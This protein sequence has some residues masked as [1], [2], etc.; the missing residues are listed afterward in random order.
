MVWMKNQ[1]A[2]LSISDDAADANSQTPLVSVIIPAYNAENYIVATL[3]S[4]LSQTYTAIEVLVVDDG[5]SDRTPDIIRSFAEKDKRVSLIQQV[6]AGVAA[7]RNLA[8]QKSR[9]EYIA[10]ID[11]DDIWFPQKLEK[12]VQCMLNSDSSVGLIY[13]WS[14]DINEDG[15]LTGRASHFSL[16]GDVFLPLVYTNFLGNA[17]VPL[18]RRECFEKVGYYNAEYVKLNAQGCED[19]DLHLRIAEHYQFRV[20]PELLVGY[21]K[22]LG[23]MSNNYTSMEKSHFLIL[24][25]VQSKY[26]KIPFEIYRWSTSNFCTYLATQSWRAGNHKNTLLWLYRAVKVD[27]VHLLDTQLYERFLKSFLKFLAQ[28]MASRVW[29]DRRSWLK[30]KEQFKPNRRSITLTDLHRR[31]AQSQ[32]DAK[33]LYAKIRAQRWN[34]VTRLSLQDVHD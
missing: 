13:A 16:E 22:V 10:T 32:V 18:I 24:E 7:A 30:F 5:S 28:P 17:S 11:A 23:S 20:V 14:A 34:Q 31:V 2:G 33:G 4:V 15:E 12:Q 27:R 29:P 21:R 3:E 19:R 9:G 26:P 8:I 1:K 25:D 6:N